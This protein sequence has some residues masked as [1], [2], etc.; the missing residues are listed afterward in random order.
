MTYNDEQGLGMNELEGVVLRCYRKEAVEIELK[1]IQREINPEKL[2]CTISS[3]SGITSVIPNES[4]K[5]EWRTPHSP[6][7]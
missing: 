5:L 7:E 3:R 6:D 2:F 4:F 1:K